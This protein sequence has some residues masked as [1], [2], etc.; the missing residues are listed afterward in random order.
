MFVNMAFVAPNLDKEKEMRDVMLQ[1]SKTLQGSPGLVRVHVLK[2]KGGN[3]LLGISMWE[4]EE[5]FN[6]GMAGASSTP[7]SASKSGA[8]QQSPA[9]VRQFVEV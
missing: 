8:L 9:I 3:T 6:Q 4:S 2:E 5:A 7:A 1:F